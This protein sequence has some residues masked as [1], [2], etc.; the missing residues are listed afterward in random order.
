MALFKELTHD[1]RH[2]IERERLS[3]AYLF[4]G[5]SLALERELAHSIGCFLET[6]EWQ[7]A[8][9]PLVDE[10]VIDAKLPEFQGIETV[11][12]LAS[13]LWQKPIRS[14]RRT[15]IICQAD[16]LTTQAENA[17]LK[18]VEEPPEHGLLILTL[19]DTA[20][21]L[22][23]LVSRFQKVYFSDRVS[24]DY[25]VAQKIVQPFLRAGSRDRSALLKELLDTPD[26]FQEFVDAMIIYLY[27]DRLTS[28]A[29]LRDLLYRQSLI[30]QLNV[31]RRLQLEAVL[32]RI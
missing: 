13:W 14:S 8:L 27:E 5:E 7:E 6:G 3:H 26:R 25:S 12:S 28:Y 24:P 20:S 4:F 11:R 17:I 16:Q 15:L 32:L 21:L 29:V 10:W 1:F 31:N 9:K 19:R 2:L 18:I 23:A 30:E 22:P